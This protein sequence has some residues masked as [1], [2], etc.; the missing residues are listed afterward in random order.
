VYSPLTLVGEGLGERARVVHSSQQML[1]VEHRRLHRKCIDTV[2]AAKV[3]DVLPRP[4]R[5]LA[6]S[7]DAAVFAEMMLRLH[8]APLVG[9]QR[10]FLRLDLE[11]LAR[12]EADHR[13][14][15][16]TIRTVAA[17]AL[18]DGLSL[19]RELDRAT[20]ATAF[21]WLDGHYF[22]LLFVPA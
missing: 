10:A 15:L 8:P 14:A 22:A 20:V 4:S 1:A 18:D 9:A 6:E 7:G 12:H 16:G 21:I 2:H 3:H 11:F 19:E 5:R 13:P 17:H